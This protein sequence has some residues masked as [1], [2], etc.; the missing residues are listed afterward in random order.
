MN[1]KTVILIPAYQPDKKLISLLD[2]LKTQYCHIV[3]V[4]DGSTGCEEIFAKAKERVGVLLV[5]EVNK[6]K[7]AAIKT[8]LNYVLNNLKDIAGVVTVDADGQH[9]PAD[10]ANV[11]AKL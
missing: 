6:G 1:L 2:V 4:D 5:H 3:L 8:G 11:A 7:G 9:T 10:I